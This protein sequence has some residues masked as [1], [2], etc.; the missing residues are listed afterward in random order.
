M[1]APYHDSEPTERFEADTMNNCWLHRWRVGVPDKSSGEFRSGNQPDPTHPLHPAAYRIYW[2]QKS[3]DFLL[4]FPDGVNFTVGKDD[5]SV[6]MNV[7]HWA[8]FGGSSVRNLSSICTLAPSLRLSYM[9]NRFVRKWRLETVT[10][11]IGH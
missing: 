8:T 4:N 11:T 3:A 6:A 1:S 9:T 10:S 5:V 7:A 2:G